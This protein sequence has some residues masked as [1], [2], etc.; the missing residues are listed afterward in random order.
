[1]ERLFNANVFNAFVGAG[2]LI[3]ACV[4]PRVMAAQT[5]PSDAE[6]LALV[7]AIDKNEITG[8][9]KAAEKKTSKP[10]LEY[11]QMLHKQHTANLD[12]TMKIAK[13]IGVDPAETP[14][15]QALHAKGD[16]E[17]AALAPLDGDQFARQYVSNMI[18][19]H[20]EALNMLDSRIS[21]AQNEDVKKLL[22]KTRSHVAMHLERAKKIQSTLAG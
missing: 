12:Q 20:T 18:Q 15:V 4:T 19:D 16:Q 21:A 2:I 13:K 3:M 22:T 1:M 14:A 6:A 5:S 7:A 11:A 9:E 10:V 8:A 17:V